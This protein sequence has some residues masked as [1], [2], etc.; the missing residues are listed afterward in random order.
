M[1]FLQ[2]LSLKKHAERLSLTSDVGEI[3]G[4]LAPFGFS[5]E[6]TIANVMLAAQAVSA[7]P[8]E[9]IS[10]FVQGGGLARIL[11]GKTEKPEDSAIEC[12]HCNQVIF[13][14]LS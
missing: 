14:S 10:S 2:L 1:D 12:P 6:K 13:L 7:D 5:D 11:A 3:A 8:T 9:T 4:L